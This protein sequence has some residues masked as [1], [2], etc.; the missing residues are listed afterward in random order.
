MEVNAHGTPL[1]KYLNLIPP[2]SLRLIGFVCERRERIVRVPA[3]MQA[4]ALLCTFVA[5]LKIALDHSMI[6]RFPNTRN[7]TNMI[8]ITSIALL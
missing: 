3:I 7:A 1:H 2:D 5:T 6:R 4:Y 8:L